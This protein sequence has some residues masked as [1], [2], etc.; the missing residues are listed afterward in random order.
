MSMRNLMWRQTRK[1]IERALCKLRKVEQLEDVTTTVE[2][3]GHILGISRGLAYDLVNS[4]CIP[5][6]PLDGRKVIPITSLARMIVEADE[7]SRTS[8]QDGEAA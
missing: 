2:E 5:S 7:R 1:G 8:T 4:G 3:A 6:I